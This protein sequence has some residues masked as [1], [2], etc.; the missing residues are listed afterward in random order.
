MWKPVSTVK[1]LACKIYV[2]MGIG[3]G[4]GA[5]GGGAWW[6]IM[7]SALDSES[8]GPGSSLAGILQE[9]HFNYSLSTQEYTVVLMGTSGF[10]GHMTKMLEG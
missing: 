6:P 1:I 5:G 4:G 9:S 3:G 10:L 8:R 2:N 7:V